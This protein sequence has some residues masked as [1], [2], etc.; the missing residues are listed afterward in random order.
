[1]L[2]FHNFQA[3]AVQD[4]NIYKYIIQEVQP[5]LDE[6]GISTPEELGLDKPD[7]AKQYTG[8]WWMIYGERD[9]WEL[10][11]IT[12]YAGIWRLS[13]SVCEL[14]YLHYKHTGSTTH[15]NAVG[16]L[17]VLVCILF[18]KCFSLLMHNNKIIQLQASV[19]L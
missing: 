14:E 15:K 6:L 11:I 12:K 8:K 19:F 9:R 17:W 10:W 13:L 5:T 1:M 3:K 16:V 4:E 18:H 7:P 2:N